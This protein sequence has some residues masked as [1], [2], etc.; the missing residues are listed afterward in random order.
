MH[1]QPCDGCA[2]LMEGT[3]H[4]FIWQEDFMSRISIGTAGSPFFRIHP[5]LSCHQALL[6]KL[7]STWHNSKVNLICPTNNC[8]RLTYWQEAL[9]PS[10]Y[11][12]SKGK[13][14]RR[15]IQTQVHE[16]QILCGICFMTHIEKMQITTAY[17]SAG[18]E[19][20]Y[21]V[22][23]PKPKSNMFMQV[24]DSMRAR[25]PIAEAL[26]CDQFQHGE[27]VT[28]TV[29]K[30]RDYLNRCRNRSKSSRID[31]LF[32]NAICTSCQT[33]LPS[34]SNNNS[35]QPASEI[36]TIAQIVGLKWTELNVIHSRSA[37]WQSVLS[38]HP[39][40][41]NSL[42]IFSCTVCSRLSYIYRRPWIDPKELQN[43]ENELSIAS[44][45]AICGEHLLCGF[46]ASKSPNTIGLGT[47][48]LG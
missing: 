4:R 13:T 14:C 27:K 47:S 26:F 11:P 10:F 36:R 2:D 12:T 34:I 16:Q 25:S 9:Y 5:R 45:A 24:E 23:S 17:L 22:G 32:E 29:N 30:T 31:P 15:M 41:K 42:A 3:N 40:F 18:K 44:K 19:T 39:G 48:M 37:C 8:N 28:L 20:E 33:L 35:N 43:L 38:C 6:A 7:P 1:N 46:C 21:H